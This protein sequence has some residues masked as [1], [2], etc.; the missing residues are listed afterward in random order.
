M[1]LSQGE[2][3]ISL[4]AHDGDRGAPSAAGGIIKPFLKRTGFQAFFQRQ[5]HQF[6]WAE[7]DYQRGYSQGFG[8][9]RKLFIFRGKHDQIIDRLALAVFQEIRPSPT[10]HQECSQKFRARLLIPARFAQ[11][12]AGRNGSAAASAI[13]RFNLADGIADKGLNRQDFFYG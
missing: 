10:G 9:V 4:E 2:K 8:P 6:Q 7:G 11:R 1:N 5:R 12:T 13:L 3:F